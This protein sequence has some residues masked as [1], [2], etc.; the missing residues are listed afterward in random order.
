MSSALRPLPSG[1]RRVTLMGCPVDLLTSKTLLEE[2]TRAIDAHVGPKVI[3]FVNGNKIAQVRKDFE[4]E[5]IL[6]RASYVL[7]DGQPLLPM[8]RMLGIRIPERI[9]GIGLMGKLLKLAD[10]R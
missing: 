1:L 10:D 5:R 9:D 2:L 6:W 8:A 7:A 3:Q 4:M